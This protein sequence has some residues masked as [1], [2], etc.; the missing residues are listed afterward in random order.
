MARADGVEVV[1]LEEEDVLH[2]RVDGE[3][4]P[5]LGVEL[6]AVDALEGDAAAVEE[7]DAVLDLYLADADL[8]GGR[9]LD[10][11][12]RVAEG[13]G[14]VVEV[15][16]LGVPE[17]RAGNLAGEL[18][19]SALRG[20]AHG[21]RLHPDGPAG[22]VRELGPDLAASE[23][24]RGAGDC[25]ADGER[26]VA[27]VGV[28]RGG[29]ADVLD[30]GLREGNERDGA[31]D[32]AQPPLV[33]VFE[34]GAGRPL[35]DADGED[36]LAVEVE[37]VRDVELVREAAAHPLAHAFAVQE[38]LE[39]GV[40]AVEADADP[41]ALPVG[42]EEECA[43]VAARRVGGGDEGLVQRDRI[44]DVGVPGMAVALH[45]PVR[46]HGDPVPVGI[47]EVGGLEAL[48]R[49]FGRGVEVEEPVAAER[50]GGLARRAGADGRREGGA[51]RK[52]VDAEIVN[53]FPGTSL[54]GCLSIEV[55]AKPRSAFAD[56][57]RFFRGQEHAPLADLIQIVTI[58]FFP[59]ALFKNKNSTKRHEGG[60]ARAPIG[61]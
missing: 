26:R 14:E 37:L 58:I 25:R 49:L 47:V 50:H 34:V 13:D 60:V 61:I 5:R 43:A 1:A 40:D 27:V 51:R 22:G 33:L 38:D 8:E 28:E 36:V 7:E 57:V 4:A 48:R 53:S 42:R 41:A 45:L 2:H 16:V 32:A 44:L 46:R 30:R 54:H 55:L 10:A 12:R 20:D 15:G 21:H 19:L 59:P 39:P 6:V 18:D 31:E 17:M 9:H 29:E 24:G 23:G 11:P 3:G 56:G 35:D 52:A